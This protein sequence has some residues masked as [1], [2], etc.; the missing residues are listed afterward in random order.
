MIKNLD[1]K[2]VL[3]VAVAIGL[4]FLSFYKVNLR[5]LWTSIAQLNYLYLLAS[6]GAAVPMNWAKGM[7]WR[8][9]IRE[10]KPVS[11][12]RMFALFH[13]GQMINL[14]L[15]ALT[16][17][18]GRIVM[19]SK[20]EGLSKTLCF[21]TVAMEVLFDGIS[22]I[23]LVYLASFIFAFPVWLRQAEIYAAIGIGVFLCVAFLVWRNKR[24]L[25][26]FGKT[27]IKRRFPNL[28][29]KL[30]KWTQSM[31]SGL[32]SLKSGRGILEVSYYSILVWLFHVLVAVTLILAFKLD[33]PAW[34]GVVVVIINSFLLMIPISPGNI[35]SF[36]IIVISVL[37]EL[38]K[39]PRAEAAAFSLVL[40]FMDIV[41]VFVIGIYFLFT[42]H[43]TFKKLR[44]EAEIE[45]QKADTTETLQP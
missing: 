17:Q 10:V 41:P 3:G 24:A 25:E 29:T 4:L 22:L 31:I 19:L 6:F 37:H 7:R 15:P 27:R 32:T 34:A 35:G 9:L 33:I 12:T 18:A 39:V 23:V 36:Q 28:Y 8:A 5:E 1:W 2:K 11:K 14:S 13:V 43:I 16:G 45:A 38:F 42:N 30:Q 40:H 44:A 20:A 26:Y 21:T